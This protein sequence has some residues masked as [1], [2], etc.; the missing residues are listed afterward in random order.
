[1]KFDEL[2]EKCVECI[3]SFNPVINT[4]DSHA[5]NFLTTVKDPY[6]KVFIKQIFYGCIRYQDFLKVFTKV[7]FERYPVGTNRND[8]TLYQIFAY[9]SFFR[10]EEIAI[11]DYRKLVMSQEPNKMHV[12]LQFT[13]DAEKLRETMREPWMEIYDF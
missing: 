5:D 7:L 10:L 9:L 2:L 11:E 6:E 13:F 12:L 4:I 8:I 3:K 1:M